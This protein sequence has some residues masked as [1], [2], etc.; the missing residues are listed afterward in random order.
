MRSRSAGRS[1]LSR[2]GDTGVSSRI[3]LKITGELSPRNG[4]KPVAISYSTEPKENKSLRPS[5][6]W[7]RACSGDM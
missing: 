2:N 5:S 4:T 6:S 1:G 7:A 3:A